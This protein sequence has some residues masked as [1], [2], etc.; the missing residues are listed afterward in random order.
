MAS[1]INAIPALSDEERRWAVVGI[2]LTKILTPSLRYVL[3]TELQKWYHHL[4]KPPIEIDKQVYPKHQ[5]KLPSSTVQLKYKNINNNKVHKKS[6]SLYDYAVKDS[7]SLAKL[8]V[9]PFMAKFTGFDQ[10]MDMSAILAVMS[11]ADPFVTSG[12]AAKAKIVRQN[13]RNKWAHC[14]FS[15]WTEPLFNAAFQDMESLVKKINLSPP[16][17][18][19]LCDDLDNWKNKGIY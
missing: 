16:V 3:A 15:E 13:I 7:L 12:A 1:A 8:F 17:E 18:K 4:C 6:H 11:E 10:T 9:E 19:A 2:S 5:N 14:N